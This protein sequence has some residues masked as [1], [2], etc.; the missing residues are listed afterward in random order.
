MVRNRSVRF[1]TGMVGVEEDVSRE[2]EMERD[3]IGPGESSD[4][5]SVSAACTGRHS[6]SKRLVCP[7]AI[8]Q[9][10]ISDTSTGLEV[11]YQPRIGESAGISTKEPLSS[12]PYIYN[13][14]Q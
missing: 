1:K 4:G 2:W 8:R 12:L 5:G 10:W 13:P 3:G 9:V 11:T 7:I 6:A 14:V